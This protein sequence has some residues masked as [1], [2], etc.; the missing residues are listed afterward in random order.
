MSGDTPVWNF[1]PSGDVPS[2][3]LPPEPAP[4]QRDFEP[5][6]IPYATLVIAALCGI[7]FLL[8]LLAGG[9]RNAF[10]LLDF[11]AS[12]RAYFLHGQ[13]FRAVM[14]LFLHIGWWHLA[15]NMLPFL[16]LGPVLEEM[17]G[18]GR[19]A[20]IYVGAGI[21]GV[22]VSMFVGH[23]ESAGAS[24]AIMGVIAAI[25]TAGHFHRDAMPFHLARIFRRGWFTIL[26]VTFMVM[27][28]ISGFTVSNVDNWGHLGGLVGGALLAL[29]IPPPAA[30]SAWAAPPSEASLRGAQASRRVNAWQAQWVVV[31]PAAIVALAM[32]RAH[33]H[34]QVAH[35]VSQ[36]LEEA[37][38]LEV[39]KRP[40]AAMDVLRKA[41]E[42]DAND[43]RPLALLGGIE[44]GEHQ[45]SQ[46]IRDLN[47]A[48]RIN[49][50][51]QGAMLD[52]ASAYQIAGNMA[53]AQQTL[54]RL[55]RLNPRN[56]EALETL[57]DLF[58]SQKR[59]R[60]AIEQYQKVLRIRPNAAIALNNLAWLYVTADEQ[61]YRNVPAAL[62]LA[63]KA[64]GLTAWRVPNFIDTLAEANYATGNFADAVKI[65]F[66]ALQLE[67]ANAEFRQHMARYRQAA[68][69][70]NPS[71]QD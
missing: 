45:T 9:S 37:A 24:G 6:P 56:L 17:Y 32:Y 65:E 26:L 61:K 60:P 18:Y 64:V 42:L 29:L 15:M 33:L 57:A 20:C 59:Y 31:I 48:V 69:N 28:I 19:Y 39:G 49:P 66:R 58:A 70:P 47:E 7:V 36:M 3:P 54:D 23:H 35:R 46:A 12:Y 63:R 38:R 30:A 2:E 52:L 1:D 21:I 13:Y 41:T 27:E 5:R 25:P 67:P 40:A 22:L 50:D 71:V 14:P 43:D 4:P 11:G 8:Q 62:D 53:E 55:L 16:L 10:V 51:S 34:Y 68:E 44:L